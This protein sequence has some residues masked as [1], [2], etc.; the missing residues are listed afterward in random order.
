MTFEH[1]SEHGIKQ[2]LFICLCIVQVLTIIYALHHSGSSSHV[3]NV[4]D[5][6]REFRQTTDEIIDAKEDFDHLILPPTTI[7]PSYTD[8]KPPNRP[9]VLQKQVMPLLY[10]NHSNVD[11][12]KYPIPYPYTRPLCPDT[13]SYHGTWA[14]REVPD[15][16]PPKGTDAKE[17][18]GLRANH[19]FFEPSGCRY[20]TFTRQ[21]LDRCLAGKRLV[22]SGDSLIRNQAAELINRY[23]EP[24]FRF[25]GNGQ[26][27][28]N[29]TI[30]TEAGKPIDIQ[31]L[32]NPDVY[33]FRPT[34]VTPGK[35]SQVDLLVLSMAPWDLGVYNF[36]VA[37]FY[38]NFTR[39]LRE[40]VASLD[41]VTTSQLD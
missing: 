11:L 2:S 23:Y 21:D 5:R 28:G 1:R 41:N 32:W 8:I 15:I 36:G 35:K 6:Q 13:R 30:H 33:S 25:W 40:T 10:Y 7:P 17:Y 22:F 19:A 39:M 14:W 3:G 34:W 16:R 12:Q 24:N 18:K 37:G 38:G 29:L 31:F 9:R 4:F 26:S 27:D 20:H